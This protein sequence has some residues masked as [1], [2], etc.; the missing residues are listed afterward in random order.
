METNWATLYFSIW[1]H[2][3]QVRFG[4]CLLYKVSL[5]QNLSLLP[6]TTSQHQDVVLSSDL[7]LCCQSSEFECCHLW[8]C[9]YSRK[10]LAQWSR[11]NSQLC[12][13]C[14]NLKL[15]SCNDL[16]QSAHLSLSLDWYCVWMYIWGKRV[17][18]F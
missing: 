11:W 17:H 12:C 3:S 2:W 16:W 8:H 18:L 1:P 6:K 4:H 7:C 9:C 5:E 15:D 10:H 14:H 13:S